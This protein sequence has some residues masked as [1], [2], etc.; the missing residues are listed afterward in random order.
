MTLTIFPPSPTLWISESPPQLRALPSNSLIRSTAMVSFKEL[1]NSIVIEL[2]N[3]VVV[4]GTVAAIT[5]HH[6]FSTY[7]ALVR[8]FAI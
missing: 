1:Q 2:Y 7:H 8:N 6:L 3:I 4:D 5:K